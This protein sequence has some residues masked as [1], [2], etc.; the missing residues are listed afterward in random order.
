MTIINICVISESVKYNSQTSTALRSEIESTLRKWFT[1]S[2][3]RDGGRQRRRPSEDN[4]QSSQSQNHSNELSLRDGSIR[5]HDMSQPN[6]SQYYQYLSYLQII[7][8]IVSLH[9]N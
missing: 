9:C 6:A 3:D 4:C 5:V 2:R 1:N 7:M 8:D